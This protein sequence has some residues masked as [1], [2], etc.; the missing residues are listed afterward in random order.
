M[1][2]EESGVHIGERVVCTLWDGSRSGGVLAGVIGQDVL[3]R[4]RG[5][6]GVLGSPERVVLA[7]APAGG[8]F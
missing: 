4:R 1:T 7:D 2:L 8:L 3:V 6:C 5:L